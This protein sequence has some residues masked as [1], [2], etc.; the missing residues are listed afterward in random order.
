MKYFP[1]KCV[2]ILRKLKWKKMEAK[3]YTTITSTY[4]L[5]RK[6]K[7]PE[8]NTIKYDTLSG[9]IIDENNVLDAG[10][11]V[12]GLLHVRQEHVQCHHVP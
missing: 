7:L 1:E 12:A 6:S 10:V 5:Y 2:T 3:T 9:F 4:S 11:D 8:G